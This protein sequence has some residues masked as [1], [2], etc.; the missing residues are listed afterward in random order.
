MC[1]GKASVCV[2]VRACVRIR[3]REC[4]RET[5]SLSP[6]LTPRCLKTDSTAKKKNR[7]GYVSLNADILLPI[8]LSVP[9]AVRTGISCVNQI[10]L[11][12]RIYHLSRVME[13]SQTSFDKSCWIIFSC[14]FQ[15]IKQICT[16]QKPESGPP[17][18]VLA[19]QL[20]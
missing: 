16:K 19:V 10:S 6:K 13:G 20:A 17:I 8:K 12:C 9:L 2:C 15:R 3:V 11:Q 18:N 7:T 14:V 5:D 1:C 4:V